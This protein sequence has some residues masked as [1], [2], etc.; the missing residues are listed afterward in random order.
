MLEVIETP[1][2]GEYVADKTQ[3]ITRVEDLPRPKLV[4]RSRNYKRRPCPICQHSAY[5]LRT[6][7]LYSAMVQ[8]SGVR[9]TKAPVGLAQRTLG[10]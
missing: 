7:T 9:P 3:G 4:R 6:D 2:P 1:G 10:G 5:R 8:F